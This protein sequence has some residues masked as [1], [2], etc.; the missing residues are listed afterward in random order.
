MTHPDTFSVFPYARAY[1]VEQEHPSR[2]V[3]CHPGQLLARRERAA[4]ENQVPGGMPPRMWVI[5]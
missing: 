4:L 1:A 3:M 2:S 5:S